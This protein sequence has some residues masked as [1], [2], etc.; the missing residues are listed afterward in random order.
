M[1]VRMTNEIV[2]FIDKLKIVSVKNL[3][4]TFH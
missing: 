4:S 1:T 3:A 2:D